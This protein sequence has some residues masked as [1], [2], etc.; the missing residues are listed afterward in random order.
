MDR[1]WGPHFLRC[2]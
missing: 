2:R 1:N